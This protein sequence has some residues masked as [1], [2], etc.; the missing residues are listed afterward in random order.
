MNEKKSMTIDELLGYIEL[1]DLTLDDLLK[2][3]PSELTRIWTEG[4]AKQMR[5]MKDI[6]D[7][8]EIKRQTTPVTSQHVVS[9]LENNI[10]SA[11]WALYTRT[12][13]S[14]ESFRKV[15]SDIYGSAYANQII[16]KMHGKGR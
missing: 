5:K 2:K 14:G 1:T 7:R 11:I 12:Q 13:E 15:L 10:S 4:T 16:D 8:N 6:I 9:S 3:C